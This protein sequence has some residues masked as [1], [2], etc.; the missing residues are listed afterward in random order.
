MSKNVSIKPSLE[1]PEEK[2]QKNSRVRITEVGALDFEDSSYKDYILDKVLFAYI[3]QLRSFLP[4]FSDFIIQ[5]QKKHSSGPKSI[6]IAMANAVG[7]IGRAGLIPCY[8]VLRSWARHKDAT[9]RTCVAHALRETASDISK[10]DEILGLLNRW[11][12]NPDPKIK[13]TV[14][15]TWERLY[16]YFP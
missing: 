4:V 1:I 2:L 7:E 8:L 13:W 16:T 3:Q 9:V 12:N 14:A 10:R 15:A 6:R 5:N 11:R